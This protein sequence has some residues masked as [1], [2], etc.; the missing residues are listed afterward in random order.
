MHIQKQ[1][2]F[3]QKCDDIEIPDGSQEGD[4]METSSVNQT[5]VMILILHLNQWKPSTWY[6]QAT[7]KM[8]DHINWF[9]VCLIKINHRLMPYKFVE[10][11]GRYET[12]LFLIQHS[13]LSQHVLEPNK[14]ESVLDI[15]LS[16]LNELI[17]NVKASLGSKRILFSYFIITEPTELKLS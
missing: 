9:E 17:E 1:N 14:G 6:K 12:F 10:Y 15:D 4:D 13:F 7:L 5:Q 3:S 8:V 11:R 2:I 16:L